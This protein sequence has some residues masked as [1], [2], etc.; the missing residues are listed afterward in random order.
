MFIRRLALCVWCA[1]TFLY[2][3]CAG[4]Y[5]W[6]FKSGWFKLIRIHHYHQPRVRRSHTHTHTH[7]RWVDRGLYFA[8]QV[9][10]DVNARANTKSADTRIAKQTF[11]TLAAPWCRPKLRWFVTIDRLIRFE[12]STQR[13]NWKACRVHTSSALEL[14]PHCAPTATVSNAPLIVVQR[15]EWT[16]DERGHIFGRGSTQR[17]TSIST[18]EKCIYCCGCS[19][20]WVSLHRACSPQKRIVRP[21]Q[22]PISEAIRETISDYSWPHSNY[23]YTDTQTSP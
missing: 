21:M 1:R 17:K 23:H 16:V 20:M 3:R 15:I 2:M 11:H 13:P 22:W 4:S 8:R 6:I 5:A 12:R 14:R 10:A 19:W 7:H 9:V 18:L